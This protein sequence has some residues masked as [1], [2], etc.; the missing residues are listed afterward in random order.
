MSRKYLLDGKFDSSD[1]FSPA[2]LTMICASGRNFTPD[3]EAALPC[4]EAAI[5]ALIDRALD[6][7][8]HQGAGSVL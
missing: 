6:R 4:C 1:L 3:P 2:H 7:R 8:S 5:F